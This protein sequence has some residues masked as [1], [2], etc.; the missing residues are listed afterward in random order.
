MSS[1]SRSP[2]PRRILRWSGALIAFV[3]F[4]VLTASALL[5]LPG[6]Q[7]WVAR[8]LAVWATERS[9]VEVRIGRFTADPFGAIT[10]W[11]VHI[12]DLEQDTLFDVGRLRIVR[13]RIN[14]AQ[15]TVKVAALEVERLRFNLVIDSTD[16]HSNLTNLV[17]KLF[18]D[19]STSSGEDWVI[20]CGQFSLDAVHF[21]YH[22]HHVAPIPWGVDV[23]HPDVRDLA[24]K[25]HGLEVIGDSITAQLEH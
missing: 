23:D 16:A 15:R 25:G 1:A 18:P 22:D 24:V 21:S 13:P 20:R 7:T 2:W 9:G 8:K 10:L 12:G 3:L 11:D 17:D 5:L 6:V 19:T 4:L 14:S